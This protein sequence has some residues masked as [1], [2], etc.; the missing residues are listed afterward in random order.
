[1]ECSVK[2]LPTKKLYRGI[3]VNVCQNRRAGSRWKESSTSEEISRKKSTLR[4]TRYP[5]S[6]RNSF[7]FPAP[8]SKQTCLHRYWLLSNTRA[9]ARAPASLRMTQFPLFSE[10]P[11]FDSRTKKLDERTRLFREVRTY[12]HL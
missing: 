12:R 11:P 7:L 2:F 5:L 3:D 4:T 9:E 8:R 1:M 6:E 10:D